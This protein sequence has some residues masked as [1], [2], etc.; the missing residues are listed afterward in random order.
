MLQRLFFYL[1]YSTV[2]ILAGCQG[3]DFKLNDKVVYAATGLFA[4]FT[5]PDQA[6]YDCLKQAIVDGAITAPEQLSVLNCSNAGIE[7]LEGLATFNAIKALRLSS[8]SIRNLVEI[9]K[10]AVL[11][12]LYLDDNQVV[13]PVPLYTLTTLH[14]IDL[15]GNTSLQCPRNGS[16]K[17]VETLILPLHC[18]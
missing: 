10:L 9:N 18:R 3:Y 1:A 11:E 17:Q 6:L 7:N 15:S 5:T 12:E 13:D 14:T 8:N 4:D 2:F 16:L